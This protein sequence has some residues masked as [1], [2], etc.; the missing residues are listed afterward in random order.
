[1]ASVAESVARLTQPRSQTGFGRSRRRAGCFNTMDT[2]DTK[3]RDRILYSL[4]LCVLG[5]LRVDSPFLVRRERS[6]LND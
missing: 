6:V 4:D 5:V 3:V 2:K 1:M